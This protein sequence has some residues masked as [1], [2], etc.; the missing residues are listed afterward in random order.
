MSE[1]ESILVGVG[2]SA[3]SAVALREAIWL[4]QRTRMRVCPVYVVDTLF[5]APPQE[6]LGELSRAVRRELVQ[7]ARAEWS[8]FV[9]RV[10]EARHLRLAVEVDSLA[11]AFARRV[12][13]ESAALIV[14]GLARLPGERLR[15]DGL[16]TACLQDIP[17]PLLLVHPSRPSPP[18]RMAVCIDFSEASRTALRH[19]VRLA[20]IQ[21]ATLHV[22]HLSALTR[23]QGEQ[24]LADRI[25]EFCAQETKKLPNSNVAYEIFD[26]PVLDGGLAELLDESSIN[27]TVL[28]LGDH[29]RLKFL[30][31]E[32]RLERLVRTLPSSILVVGPEHQTLLPEGV[33]PAE[34]T[35]TYGLTA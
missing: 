21:G 3:Q 35:V 30:V 8:Q 13:G 7:R 19:A 29:W 18:A 23:P 10:P 25:H 34:E 16:E 4:A 17:V 12:R 20:G 24:G 33:W 28:G 32:S 9:L 27:L 11:A 31:Q 6:V 5:P 2:F 26:R 1:C 14:V 22:L 15:P